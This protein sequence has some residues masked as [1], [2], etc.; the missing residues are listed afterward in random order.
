MPRV[1]YASTKNS[2]MRYALKVDVSDPVFLLEME[3][4]KLVFLDSREIGVFEK[5]N[6]DKNIKAILLDPILGEAKKKLEET[7]NVNKLAWHLFE[8]YKMT[9]VDVPSSFPLDMADFLRAKGIE[10]K[11]V[12]PFYPE[13]ERKN[14]KE[15]GCVRMNLKNLYPAYERIEAI[16]QEAVIE[17]DYLKYQGDFLTSEFMKKEVE[18]VLINH[19]LFDEEGMIISCAEDSA[20]PHHRGSG[21]LKSNRPIICDIFPRGRENGYFADMTRTYV[22][23]IANSEFEKMY[24]AVSFVQG[25]AIKMVAPGVAAK[26]IYDFCAQTFL[27]MG[28]DV[29]EKGFTHGTGHGL[30]LDV[31][32]NPFVNK[33]SE[34]ILEEGNIITIEPGLYY[35]EIGGVRI[36]DNILVTKDGCENLTQYH[37]NYLI[38]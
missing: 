22:K 33:Y 28:F 17:G 1:I 32:E 7:S 25:Q 26:S 2:D 10:I 36:E 30:G 6:T 14:E 16:L 8:V 24:A 9:S 20:I 5:H 15:A 35:P 11:I 13:R 29:G 34:A 23:G 27:Q 38:K 3:E 12:N 21:I 4:E 19:D 18:H 31:H 37:K